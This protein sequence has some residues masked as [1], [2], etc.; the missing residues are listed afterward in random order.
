VDTSECGSPDTGNSTI[1]NTTLYSEPRLRFHTVHG[2]NARISNGGLTASRLKALAEFNYSIVFSNRPL[3][4]R[5]L[6]EVVLETMIDHWNGSIEIGVTGIR[7]DELN[8][9]ST[10]TDLDHDTIMLSGTAVMHN[11]RNVRNTMPFD[12]DSLTSGTK[13]GI[14]RNMDA[15][16]LFINGVDQGQA[17]ECR[18]S[19]VYAVIDLY[20]QC[21]QVSITSPLPDIRAPYATSENSQSLQATSVIQPALEAKHR[22]SCISGNVS[23]FQN[24][25]IAA[26]CTN[27]SPALSQCLAFSERPLVI[28][29]PFEIKINEI[30]PMFAGKKKNFYLI[31]GTKFILC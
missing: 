15:I 4:Q 20:G 7:P 3:R 1:S 11:G 24:F 9:P 8:L 23:L 30:N 26:R 28:G 18:I 17:Y 6:F 29:E 2:R 31:R 14:M 21:A 25:T 10:A 12:L 5:E 13:I 22:W 19:N 16:H 27:S